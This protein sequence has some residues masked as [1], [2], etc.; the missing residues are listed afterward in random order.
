MFKN[1]PESFT[2]SIFEQFDLD[3]KLK[4]RKP[5]KDRNNFFEQNLNLFIKIIHSLEPK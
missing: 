3:E 5:V 4:L 1:R 2:A